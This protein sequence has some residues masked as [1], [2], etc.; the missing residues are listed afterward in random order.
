MQLRPYQL[1]LIERTRSALRQGSRRIILQLPT[2]GGK[3]AIAGEVVRRLSEAG[4]RVAYTVPRVE[5]LDQ[6]HEKLQ[7]LEIPHF[8]LRAGVRTHRIAA[9]DRV[10][11]AMAPTMA[12]RLD[13]WPAWW[14]PH[15]VVV[16]ECHYA[17]D[18]VSAMQA[19]WPN[20]TFLGL[21]A[22]PDRM[23]D[24]TLA[25][26]YE[27]IIAG[28]DV[29]QLVQAGYLVPAV[30]FAAPS[31]NLAGIRRTK[32]DYDAAE[33]SRRFSTDALMGLVPEAWAR[34]APGKRTIVFAASRTHGKQLASKFRLR[35]VRVA[36]VDGASAA[37]ER[38]EALANLR[39]G[40]LTV[41]VNVGLFVEGLDLVQIECIVLA[42]ATYSLSRYLQMV[43]RGLRI[44]PETGKRRLVVIDHGGNC[45]R[46]GMP[47]D[48]R[49]WTLDRTDQLEPQTHGLRECD[50]CGAVYGRQ[51][52][53]CPECG[54]TVPLPIARGPRLADREHV[55]VPMVQVSVGVAVRVPSREERRAESAVTPPRAPPAWVASRGLDA[56]ARWYGL[57]KERQSNGYPLPCGPYHGW[58]E[59]RMRAQG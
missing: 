35:G 17:P 22:T 39:S 48:A 21:S 1:S 56:M 36:Y 38:E 59:V 55:D 44:S 30:V 25:D 7:E 34:H 4:M 40:Q 41:I 52:H 53:T 28:P 31:P 20:A 5:I 9:D 58:T 3:T 42:T 19:M 51:T 33:L 27:V 54:K 32:G 13:A 2:G 12:R 11:L 16:D 24:D 50:G 8:V 6:T 46:H 43:G 23:G 45:L 10:V 26:L 14:S 57:E 18:Q 15:V 37:G 47:D 29:P 49:V